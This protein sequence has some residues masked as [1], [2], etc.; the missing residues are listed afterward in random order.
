VSRSDRLLTLAEVAAELGLSHETVYRLVRS[1]QLPGLKVGT[2]WRF[3]RGQLHAYLRSVSSAIA[4][5]APEPADAPDEP[6]AVIAVANHKGGVGKTTTTANLGTALAEH[7]RVL[8]VDCDPQ[9]S[10][11]VSFG[12]LAAD[13]GPR[14]GDALTGRV[15]AVACVR[16]DVQPH[17][18]LL[19]A[20]LDLEIDE[21]SL[22]LRQLGRE[23]TMREALTPLL[24][25][26]RYRYVLLDCPPRLTLLTTAALVAASWVLVPVKAD[27]LGIAGMDNLLRL[28]EQVRARVNPNLTV[29]GILATFFDSRTILAR[30]VLEQLATMADGRLFETRI[31]TAIRA[32]EAPA[33]GVPVLVHDPDAEISRAF[34]ALAQEVRCRVA[35][36]APSLAG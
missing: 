8:L 5:A 20:S 24:R 30:Q 17:V 27:F 19:P 35:Q 21:Q 16:A 22:S 31:R 23:L 36:S 6:P 11:S 12:A 32:A 28:V 25:S 3:D 18:D 4:P 10:L 13:D 7:G 14:L 2:Q 9:A 15:P 1:G 26:G 33:Y 34:R 29:L